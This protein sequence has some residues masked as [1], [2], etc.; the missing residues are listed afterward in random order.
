MMMLTKINEY[1]ANNIG[2]RLQR[3]IKFLAV[4][5]VRNMVLFPSDERDAVECVC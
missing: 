4:L 1:L 3:H 2:Q 5:L